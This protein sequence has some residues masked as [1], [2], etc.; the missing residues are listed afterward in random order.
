MNLTRFI[1]YCAITALITLLFVPI[2]SFIFKNTT[3]GKLERNPPLITSDFFPRGLT[4]APT[5]AQF[6]IED[7]NSGLS[8]IAINAKQRSKS[9]KIQELQLNGETKKE[10]IINFPLKDFELVE[11]D[12]DIEIQ[13]LDNSIWKNATEA[14]FPLLVDYN[15]PHLKPISAINKVKEGGSQII[16]YET[17]D[18][19]LSIHGVKI[20]SEVF[21]GFP[22]RNLDKKI[23]AKHLFVSLFATKT[24][25][26]S[27]KLFSED[28]PGN[29]KSI[30]LNKK[31]TSK[32]EKKSKFKIPELYLRTSINSLANSFDEVIKE[33]ITKNPAIFKDIE[34]S[35]VKKFIALQKTIKINDNS[36]IKKLT[37][38]TSFEK[39]WN[40][41]FSKPSSKI[42]H[43]F[44]D[45]IKYFY[46]EKKVTE[47]KSNGIDFQLSSN[48]DEVYAAN[49]GIV[50]YAGTLEFY[51][52]TIIV[53]HGLGLTSI[54]SGF[55]NY[56]KEEGSRVEQG[57]VIATIKQG[58][59]NIGKILHFEIRLQGTP[60]DPNEWFSSSWHY[61]NITKRID[62]VKDSLGIT[63]ARRS[64]F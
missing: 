27:L 62:V 46:K 19:N 63:S 38:E 64:Q 15:K 44:N 7:K 28:I 18:Q 35:L 31:I 42:I 59:S 56:S 8:K 34:S 10:I 14:H 2:S 4:N 1:K 9:Y 53:D 41:E 29:A 37:K 47:E 40:N 39:L 3:I 21:L 5:S 26:D 57:E 32:A 22:I 50:T 6:I 60:V 54:Y 20:N 13:A 43:N 30:T 61:T 12:L 55:D 45:T 23:D 17:F 16:V 36:K 11:G 58:M 25:P 51:G 52:D 33:Y 48:L 24:I 49:S